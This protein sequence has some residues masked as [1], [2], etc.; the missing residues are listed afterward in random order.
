MKKKFTTTELNE[1]YDY[2]YAYAAYKRIK[3]EVKSQGLKEEAEEMAWTVFRYVES[4][5][6]IS[7]VSSRIDDDILVT[8]MRDG[9]ILAEFRF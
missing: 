4:N 3:H 9:K 6:D 2:A 8:C 1:L 5:Y 7:F